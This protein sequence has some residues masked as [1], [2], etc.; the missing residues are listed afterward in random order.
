M[1]LQTICS[2]SPPALAG[3]VMARHGRRRVGHHLS[4]AAR[5]RPAAGRR[6]RVEPRRGQRRQLSSRRSDRAPAAAVQPGALSALSSRRWPGAVLGAVLLLAT[7]TR[8][9]EQLIPLLLG[10]ATVLFALCRPHHAAGC[11]RARRRAA[12]ANGR[13]SVTSIPL[14]LP[15]SVY[16]GYF[17]AG[18]GVLAARRADRSRPAA[19]IARPMSPRTWCRA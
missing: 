15:I 11:A 14:V 13:S 18:V 8:M 16:G 9:F 4:G 5:G 12:A 7:P 3:G 17:G 10:F 1:D 19:T 2:C 6:D